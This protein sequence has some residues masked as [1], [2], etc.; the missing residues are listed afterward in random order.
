MSG[1]HN[2]EMKLRAVFRRDDIHAPAMLSFK[3]GAD[4]LPESRGY[5]SYDGVAMR[6]ED[7]EP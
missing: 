7:M 4:G 3:R 2:G 6:I 1:E 5:S